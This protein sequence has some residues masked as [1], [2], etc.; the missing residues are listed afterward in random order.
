[1]V[2]SF[3]PYDS[4]DTSSLFGV[5]YQTGQR[6]FMNADIFSNEKIEKMDLIT[7]IVI[8]NIYKGE[9]FSLYLDQMKDVKFHPELDVFV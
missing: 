3:L 2:I 5:Y 6:C 9:I 7:G 1:M 4:Y 8:S